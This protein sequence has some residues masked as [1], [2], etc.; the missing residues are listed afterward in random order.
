MCSVVQGGE[1]PQC[2]RFYEALQ[3]WGTIMPGQLPGCGHVSG[4]LR[5][6]RCRLENVAQMGTPQLAAMMDVAQ[7]LRVVD[8][9]GLAIAGGDLP[10]AGG[11]LVSRE[12]LREAGSRHRYR[13]QPPATPNEFW[14]MDFTAP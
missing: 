10:P 7:V 1:C 13:Y 4:E 11:G 9:T 3:T 14:N 12:E 5:Y 8:K 6:A 2:Q